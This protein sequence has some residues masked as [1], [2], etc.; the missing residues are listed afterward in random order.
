M[1]KS[2]SIRCIKM[3]HMHSVVLLYKSYDGDGFNLLSEEWTH[4]EEHLHFVQLENV[5]FDI[6]EDKRRIAQE[7]GTRTVHA[8]ARGTLVNALPKGLSPNKDLLK[9]IANL[10][11][12][13]YRPKSD[14]FFYYVKNG[15]EIREA[16][17]LYAYDGKVVVET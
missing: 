5:T 10:P 6:F 9:K 4:T 7:R 15:E 2:I 1:E 3:Q 16:K 11:Q 8:V 13:D 14:A 12:I 17:A